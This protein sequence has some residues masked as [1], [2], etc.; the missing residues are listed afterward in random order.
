M[1]GGPWPRRVALSRLAGFWGQ[2]LPKWIA[3][4]GPLAACRA[5]G[6]AVLSALGFLVVVGVWGGMGRLGGEKPFLLHAVI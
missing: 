2:L 4:E 6:A 1:L 3:G 5:A